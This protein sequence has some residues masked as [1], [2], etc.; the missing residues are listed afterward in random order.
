MRS[1]KIFLPFL[2]GNPHEIF[3]KNMCLRAGKR[4]IEKETTAATSAPHPW[5]QLTIGTENHS[6]YMSSNKLFIMQVH[7]QRV[8]FFICYPTLL[9]L[10]VGDFVEAKFCAAIYFFSLFEEGYRL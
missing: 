9:S 2:I 10:N 3:V 7:H 8:V 1:F 5:D 4:N 6:V